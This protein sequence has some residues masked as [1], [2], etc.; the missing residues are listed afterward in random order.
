MVKLIALII[1]AVAAV[2]TGIFAFHV[3]PWATALICVGFFF[4][5]I[6]AYIVFFFIVWGITGIGVDKKKQYRMTKFSR[7]IMNHYAFVCLSLFGVKV[8]GENL[9][10]LDE[11]DGPFILVSN[12][13]SNVDPLSICYLLRKRKMVFIY[14]K[15]LSKI[16]FV[17]RMI[18]RN[19]YIMLDRGDL[20]QQFNALGHA[21]DTINEEGIAVA[22]FPEGTR[23]KDEEFG[24]FKEGF[25]Y[26]GK[27]TC[28]PI[29]LVSLCGTNRVNKGLLFR[30]HKAYVKV[31]DVI[32]YDQYKDASNVEFG[33]ECKEKIVRGYKELKEKYFN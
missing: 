25:L 19:G 13:K 26:M 28:A 24:D 17:S 23:H 9:E 29:V 10:K 32:R 11:I 18:A 3:A 15:E 30:R 22:L 5:Y 31:V 2:L 4:A 8:Y 6:V 33:D 16:P 7:F 12:H 1:C 27:K 14:K 21:I 20:K